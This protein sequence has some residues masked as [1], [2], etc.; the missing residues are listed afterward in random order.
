MNFFP[1]MQIHFNVTTPSRIEE[2][3]PH[4]A[5]SVG[6]TFVQMLQRILR[7]PSSS[8]SSSS[9][10]EESDIHFY[11]NM[12]ASPQQ[13][14]LSIE[15]LH[16]MTTLDVYHGSGIDCA[17]CQNQC[18]EGNIIRVLRSCQHSFHSVC[19][20]RWLCTNSSCPVCRTDLLS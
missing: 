6:Q 10:L 8:S 11:V 7:H 16:Q 13:R 5:T 12:D 14:G 19:I 2:N 18:V 15:Q 9:P 1:N 17:I 3:R 20:D 4:S